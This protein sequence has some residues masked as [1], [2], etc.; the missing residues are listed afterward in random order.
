MTGR[1]MFIS[2]PSDIHI[3]MRPVKYPI[4][5]LKRITVELLKELHT[6]SIKY[7]KTFSPAVREE[8][9][10]VNIADRISRMASERAPMRSIAAFAIEKMVKDHPFWDGNHRTAYELGRL[11]CI[12]F[13]NRLDVSVEEAVVFM[14][15]IDD[16][17]LPAAEIARWI[18]ERKIPMK[19]P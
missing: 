14:R 5:D 16:E 18:D 8:G 17:N 15:N 19:G 13:G 2:N 3:V 1:A 12:F 9:S 4:K 11:I 6:V 10:L 7:G